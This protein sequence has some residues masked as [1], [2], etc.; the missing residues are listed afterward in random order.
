MPTDKTVVV[1]RFRDE[2]GDWRICVLTPFGG[3]VHA[4]WAMALQA[5]LRDTLSLEVQSLWSDDGIALHLPDADAP[6]SLAELLVEP[7]ELEDLVVQ[8][9]GRTALFGSRFRENAG[10]ALLIPR[11]RPGQRTPLWQQRL[12][13]QS[14]LEVARPYGSFPIILETYRECLQDVFDLPA[15]RGILHGL[16]S[17]ELDLVELETP[18]ASPMASSLLFDYVATYMYE[19]DTPA[20]ERRAQ[21]LSLDRD[22]LRELLGQEELRDLARPRRP[23][24]RR[25][26][27]YDP[28]RATRTSCTT[29][30]AAS[31]SCATPR[32]TRGSPRPSCVSGARSAR[33]SVPP[34]RSSRPRTRA[35]IATRSA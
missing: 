10:R 1:E 4:P 8:E 33:M 14:L 6:P 24:R 15:L 12:K 5:K 30:F 34:R 17:R 11:R 19:D 35:S 23:R 26:R 28:S 20:A 2:I 16:R 13:A 21:A 22:L 31:A 7:E 29:C 3:R 32:S 25:D 9:V 18:S 27:R